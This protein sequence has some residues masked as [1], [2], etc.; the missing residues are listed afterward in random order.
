MSAC[1][2]L[3]P[4]RSEVNALVHVCRYCTSIPKSLSTLFTPDTHQ[5]RANP[6]VTWEGS[7]L[8]WCRTPKILGVTFDPHFTFT[9]HIHSI[10]DRDRPRINILK[11][12]AGS[13]WG[14][15]KETIVI[16]FKSLIKSIFTYAAPI[17]LPNA[18]SSAIAKLQ[19]IQNSALRIATGSHKMAS[20][21]HLHS[22]TE[23]LPVTNHLSLL[24]SQSLA[25]SLRAPVTQLLCNHQAPQHEGNPSVTLPA[26]SLS[27]PGGW[28]SPGHPVPRSSVISPHISGNILPLL[29][30]T[31][32]TP[33]CTPPPPPIAPLEKSLP[34]ITRTT[35]SQ[36][37]SGY[38]S[39][40]RSYQARIGAAPTAS[41]P[42]CLNQD[43]NVGHLFDCPAFPTDL[44]TA[45]LWHRPA[46]VADFLS[47][48]PSFSQIPP[49][50]TRPP[51]EPPPVLG[52]P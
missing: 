8:A 33:P 31:E 39:R 51:P 13:N 24:C 14:Q 1:V 23:V 9:P 36:L 25:G 37:R 50:R 43:H 27:S 32:Q 17:W 18:S 19:S 2:T 3:N 5:S 7:D 40:L 29:R 28:H 15:Q 20:V 11:S 49:P 6:Q 45:D 21:S 34:R 46:A 38:C 30:T 10:C 48:L 41:C 35:L 16:T 52:R 47:I 4:L 42:E 22:E 44:T 26:L 12:L